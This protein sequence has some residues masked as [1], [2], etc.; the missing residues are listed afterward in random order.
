MK[1]I[2]I[3]GSGP[4]GIFSTLLLEK[5][6]GQIVLF[7]QNKRIGEKLRITGGGR[8]N[9]TNKIFSADEFSSESSRLLKNLFK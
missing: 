6:E 1:N 2:A 9:V 5:F 4:A 8:M 7:D 3:I